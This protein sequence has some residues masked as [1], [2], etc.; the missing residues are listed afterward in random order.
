MQ[1]KL[2]GCQEYTHG[3]YD[4]KLLP[5]DDRKFDIC[6]RHNVRMDIYEAKDYELTKINI[7]VKGGLCR[8]SKQPSRTAART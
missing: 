1:A 8:P 3:L 6:V 4:V 2:I 7:K 5:K